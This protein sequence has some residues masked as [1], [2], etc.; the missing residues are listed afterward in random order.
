[1]TWDWTSEKQDRAVAKLKKEIDSWRPFMEALRFEDR[2]L[3]R[4]ITNRVA[5]SY[6]DAVEKAERG[7]DTEAVLMSILLS[8]Q[9]TINWLAQL[10]EGLKKERKPQG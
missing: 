10:V 2:E 5:A 7:Y 1:M 3:F 4:E 6:A 9:K 8:Q